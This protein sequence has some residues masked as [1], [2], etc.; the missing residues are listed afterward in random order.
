MLF[1]GFF[2]HKTAPKK[3]GTF[4]CP[5]INRPRILLKSCI[6]NVARFLLGIPDE[7][8][9]GQKTLKQILK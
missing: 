9:P 6:S 3:H 4:G 5:G 8:Q 1:G 7:F 2:L